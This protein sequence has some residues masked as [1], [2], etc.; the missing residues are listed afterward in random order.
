M[1]EKFGS[2]LERTG[3]MFL[4]YG[5]RSVSMD[6]ICREIGISKKTLYQYVGNKKELIEKILDFTI[7]EKL[8]KIYN[9]E[10]GDNNAIDSLLETS[11]MINKQFKMHNTSAI[12]DLEKYYPE[13]Y[14]DFLEKRRDISLDW[15]DNNLRQG[16]KEG[17]YR[18]DLDVDLVALLYVQKLEDI[19]RSES[20][21]MKE[22]S[23][24]KIFEVMFENHIRGISNKSGIEYFEKKKETL[25]FE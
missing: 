7:Q 18:E 14:K 13:L 20:L 6:D 10:T 9:Q 16:K 2:I 8:V 21:V 3:E 11:K 17:L 22:I 12:F 4:K 25:D 19:T 1:D 24:S 15:I 5:I 23:F